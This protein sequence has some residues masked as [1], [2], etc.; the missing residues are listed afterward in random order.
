VGIRELR[1][2]FVAEWRVSAGWI[3]SGLCGWAVVAGAG[4]QSIREAGAL[5]LTDAV[6]HDCRIQ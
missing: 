3:D 1:C 5:E 6:H 4:Q 2:P